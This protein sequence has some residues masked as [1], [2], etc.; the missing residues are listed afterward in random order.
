VEEYVRADEFRKP[1]WRSLAF[2]VIV[3]VVLIISGFVFL[4]I[5]KEQLRNAKESIR[6]GQKRDAASFP[7]LEKSKP[8]HPLYP[9]ED[10]VN[11]HRI[12]SAAGGLSGKIIK[13]ELPAEADPK[14]R[15]EQY[16]FTAPRTQ[17]H[18]LSEA[19]DVMGAPSGQIGVTETRRLPGGE[20][21]SK[22]GTLS[23][24][25]LKTPDEIPPGQAGRTTRHPLPKKP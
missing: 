1:Y 8:T 10:W 2:K 23:G 17:V 14:A 13:G 4:I 15:A 19:A 21:Q 20:G 22:R 9:P 11:T 6:P 5:R 12:D 25:S 3:L 18:S 16:P 24:S 7:P